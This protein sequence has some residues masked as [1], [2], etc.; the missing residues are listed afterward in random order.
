MFNALNAHLRQRFDRLPRKLKAFKRDEQGAIALLFALILLP[1]M[2][3]MGAGIDYSRSVIDRSQAQDALDAAVLATVKQVPY[4]TDG[5]L[6][7]MVESFVSANTP[8]AS[9]I[10]VDLVEISRN[11]NT[12]KVWASGSTKMTFMKLAHVETVDFKAVSKAEA[13]NQSIEVVMVLDNSGSM[14]SSMGTLRA[15]SKEL[16]DTLEEH[17]KSFKELKIGVVPFNHLIRLDDGREDAK[18]LDQNAKSSIHRKNLPPKSNRFKILKKLTDPDTG[19]AVEWEGCMEARPHPLDVKDSAPVANTKDSYFVP[20]FYPDTK[21]YYNSVKN[22]GYQSGLNRYLPRLSYYPG[23]TN[24]QKK[25]WGYYFKQT[26]YDNGRGP[27]YYCYIQRLQPLTK[28]LSTVRTKLSGMQAG[29]YTNI[30]MGT[31]WG[32]RLLSPQE[33]YTQGASYS[34]VENRKF[35]IVM[36]DGA[37]TYSSHYQAYGWAHD[38]RISGS[39]SI[40][41]EMNA[42]TSESCEEAKGA[43]IEVFTI[44]YNNPGKTTEDM[45]KACA[46]NGGD[47]HYFDADNRSELTAAFEEIAKAISKVRLTE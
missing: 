24:G 5:E 2:L 31:I 16:V 23:S 33:P 22:Y 4:L 25:R 21:E 8:A 40:R 38:G 43:G 17:K 15:A 46:T 3:L 39:S 41:N 7:N 34:D 42:R 28:T 19:K 10:N 47:G 35:L 6:R 14:S 27:N 11:P 26:L 37:N 1:M 30:H 12:L 20:Y 44:A 36:T 32:V 29:G 45:M 13:G 18:W 9:N